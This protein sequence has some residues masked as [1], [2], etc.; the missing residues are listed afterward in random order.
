MFFNV[1]WQLLSKG[2]DTKSRRL[3]EPYG[4]SPATTQILPLQQERNHK[5]HVKKQ[6]CICPSKTLFTKPCSSHIHQLN[7]G[8]PRDRTGFLGVQTST[9]GWQAAGRPPATAVGH[10]P[11]SQEATVPGS[12]GLPLSHQTLKPH[13]NTPNTLS[14][15]KQRTHVHFFFFMK[16]DIA[17]LGYFH[18]PVSN[19]V[20]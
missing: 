2:P 20:Q 11:A 4:L 15:R 10:G 8:Q 19:L 14:L 3:Y 7:R 18:K 13:V 9:K 5:Q 16:P 6:V 12:S 17:S 1:S